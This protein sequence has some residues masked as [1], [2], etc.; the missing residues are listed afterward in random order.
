M[1]A[2]PT[3]DYAGIQRLISS[4]ALPSISLN[5]IYGNT[6]GLLDYGNPGRFAK[7]LM[8]EPI[9]AP[10]FLFKTLNDN[11]LVHY[12]PSDREISNLIKYGLLKHPFVDPAQ[13]GTQQ[14]GLTKGQK[15]VNTLKKRL[16][17]S[18]QEVPEPEKTGTHGL[19]GSLLNVLGAPGGAVTTLVYDLVNGGD[20]HPL[21]DIGHGLT[22]KGRKVGSDILNELGIQNKWA[23]GLGGFALDVVLDPT[24]YIG[25][26]LAKNA[27]THGTR[28][29][30]SE[31]LKDAGHTASKE[32]L[33]D[34]IKRAIHP[35]YRSEQI[36]NDPRIAVVSQAFGRP[37]QRLGN[38]GKL[39]Q[40]K[41]SDAYPNIPNQYQFELG[42]PFTNANVKLADIT[43]AVNKVKDTLS[44]LPESNNVGLRAIGRAG[45]RVHDALGHVFNPYPIAS[46]LANLF[47]QHDYALSSDYRNVIQ[48]GEVLNRMLG[49]SYKKNPKLHEAVVKYLDDPQTGEQLLLN[50]S[51]KEF[52]KAQQV[53]PELKQLF[54]DLANQDAQYG[55]LHPS[56]ARQFYFPHMVEGPAASKQAFNQMLN[57]IR[58]PKLQTS[59]R[60]H[61]ERAFPKIS[62]LEDFVKRFNEMHKDLKPLSVNYDVGRAVASRQLAS[63]KLKHDKTLIDRLKNLGGG[64]I[65]S[66]NQVQPGDVRYVHIPEEVPGFEGY[67]AT[68][69]VANFLQEW[70]DITS[71]E[72]ARGLL[73]IVGP[74][75]KIWKASVTATGTHQFN[76]LVGSAWNN[77]IMGVKN[78]VDYQR[79]VTLLTAGK[80]KSANPSEK[81]LKSVKIK[82]PNGN[83]LNGQQIMDL[84]KQYNII[85]AGS[86]ADYLGRTIRRIGKKNVL[87][88]VAGLPQTASEFTDDLG[89]LAG[90]INQL[91]TTGDP[92]TSALNVK[93]HLF[94]YT[95][96][97][98]TEK[99]LLNQAIPFY[100]W[101][102]KNIPLQLEALF[103]RPGMYTGTEHAVQE[104][105]K[106]TGVN[107]EDMP[108][109][110]ANAG[111]VPLFK[112]KDGHVVYMSPYALPSYDLFEALDAL[113]SPG[114]AESYLMQQL[115]PWF[116]AAS[117]IA[118]NEQFFNGMPID[119]IAEQAGTY[120]STSSILNYLFEQTGLPYNIARSIQGASDNQE[121]VTQSLGGGPFGTNP[122][123]WAGFR[124]YNPDYY[125]KQVQPYQYA[126][127]LR[128]DIQDL[129]RK[130]KTVYTT[131]EIKQAEQLGITPEQVRLLRSILDQRGV[132][133]TQ[134]NLTQLLYALQE[135]GQMQTTP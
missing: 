117:E 11:R 34:L 22:G 72:T 121:H 131:T 61:H 135:Q 16:Q 83:I 127:Q 132:R 39:P 88:K 4:S 89:R 106:A 71:P 62:E 32:E 44:A 49:G 7:Y 86:E 45:K 48:H 43:P 104:G 25:V 124:E 40:F 103:R 107:P 33:D 60:F 26:G 30:A 95:E 85:N 14:D 111:T 68:P 17:E 82:T 77:W 12:Q 129:T 5:Q 116:K 1:M 93:K 53:I 119:P 134:K 100:A 80:G 21:R 97:S 57:N 114:K 15:Q 2:L 36:V 46:N 42:I 115:G 54:L 109:Y 23:K 91:K 55:F 67:M 52:K 120:P 6:Q 92:W 18:G 19:V 13:T 75:S 51:E 56:R 110:L 10:D 125:T 96:L 29:I 37:A 66:V 73:K 102:R 69:E 70:N 27:L 63:Q 78:P 74:L 98:K 122:A 47:K 79:A 50:L 133:K 76:N 59:S 94:D 99:D 118:L 38:R 20:F 90:F 112:T 123:G 31:A 58:M 35:D 9:T 128:G 101:M 84:A 108:D 28:K 24:S 41:L 113:S 64:Y 8:P 126:D 130:G 105:A 81:A 65:K 87:T 3:V